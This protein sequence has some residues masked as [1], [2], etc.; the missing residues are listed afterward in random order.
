MNIQRLK[1]IQESLYQNTNV[2]FTFWFLFGIIITIS[3]Y[4]SFEQPIVHDRAYHVY[5]SQVIFRDDPLYTATTFGYTPFST[6]IV[7][8]FMKL[9]RLASLNTIESARTIGILLYGITCGYFFVLCKTLFM[10]KN[11]PLIGCILFCG[12]G[13]LPILSGINAEPKLWVILF[14]ILGIISFSKGNW[15]LCGLFFSL[16][17]MSW[18]VAVISLFACAITLVW[19]SRSISSSFL[20]LGLGIFLGTLPVLFYL[21]MSHGWLEFWQQAVLRKLIIEG[22][23]L[24]ESPFF[25]FTRGSYPFLCEI[26]H[27]FFGFL[28][29][30]TIIYYR[31]FVKAKLRTIFKDHTVVNLLIN[32]TFLWALFNFIE[33]KGPQDL[34]PL[35]PLIIIFCTSF[36]INSK[37]KV[38]NR[39]RS[40]IFMTFLIIYSYF[41][42]VVY[43][44]PFTYQEEKEVIMNL[45]SQYGN[46]FVIGFETFYTILE[47]PMPTKFMRYGGHEDHMIERQENGCTGIVNLIR[48][49][50]III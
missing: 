19:R 47:K 14:S 2:G 16:A 9:G 4:K 7:G 41:D 6:I 12:L 48:Q 24:G 45:E 46:P 13:Y 37:P 36:I 21:Y 28:G 23:D 11:A 25:W 30:L 31:L 34:F 38:L 18:H 40:I 5:M 1:K 42:A 27:L 8:L 32:Y 17:A 3:F 43:D 33:F 20:M 50:N 29:F 22:K 39:F 10:E 49:K 44:L 26:L 15:L 35:L